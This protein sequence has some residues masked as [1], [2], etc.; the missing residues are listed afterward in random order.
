MDEQCVICGANAAVRVAGTSFCGSCGVKQYAAANST[1]VGRRPRRAAWFSLLTSSLLLKS[2]LGA[3][4]VAA[5]GG[6]AGAALQPAEDP[7]LV[8]AGSVTTTVAVASTE[9][10]VT[11]GTAEV[12]SVSIDA[13]QEEVEEATSSSDQD[14]AGFVA[15]IQSWADCIS[16]AA[17]AHSGGRFDPALA[18]DERPSPADYG[19]GHSEDA[20]GH[21]EDGPG[22]SEDAP[23]HDEDGPGNSQDA[24]GQSNKDK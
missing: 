15:A 18:C 12:T 16:D 13:T 22:N 23:G 5:V 6:V 1:Q 3:V 20:P 24:P 17:S 21:D 4:A 2:L 8:V 14:V 11:T 10:P 19:L 9:P 7:V